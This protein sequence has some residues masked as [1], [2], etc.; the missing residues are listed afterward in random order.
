MPKV[1]REIER[2]SRGEDQ[3]DRLRSTFDMA[4]AKSTIRRFEPLALKI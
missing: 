1:P 4:N 2:E 3:I